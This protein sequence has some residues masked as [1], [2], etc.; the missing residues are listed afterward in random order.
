VGDERHCLSPGQ[1]N[2]FPVTVSSSSR[3]GKALGVST[4]TVAHY[5]H[6]AIDRLGAGM[7]ASAWSDDGLIE[8]AEAEDHP[9]ALG[10]QWHPEVDEDPSLFGALVT[11]SN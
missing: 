1:Y 4:V 10:V 11:H 2:R 7:T 9:F 8:A 5:H 6:Q 3:L